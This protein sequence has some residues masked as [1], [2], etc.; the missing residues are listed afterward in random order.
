M[1]A[2]D[3]TLDVIAHFASKPPLDTPQYVIP[4]VG[5][6]ERPFFGEE[7]TSAVDTVRRHELEFTRGDDGVSNR[8]YLCSGA[9]YATCLMLSR[10]DGAG[11]V[12]HL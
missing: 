2:V 5:P 9:G 6:R 7:M 10:V 8:R 3:Y 12:T 4:L 11:A 1:D